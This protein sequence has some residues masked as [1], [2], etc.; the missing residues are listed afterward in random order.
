MLVG[1]HH[2]CFNNSSSS[3]LCL[4]MRS[5][6][7]TVRRGV[8]L[9]HAGALQNTCN[10]FGAAVLNSCWRHRTSAGLAKLASRY[11]WSTQQRKDHTCAGQRCSQRRIQV[12]LAA[13]VD[14]ARLPH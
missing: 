2:E 5:I 13:L 1:L 9:Q 10:T 4:C 14:L 3:S 11:R 7:C 8:H 12:H 6:D